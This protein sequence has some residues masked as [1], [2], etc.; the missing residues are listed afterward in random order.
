MSMGIARLALQKY[1]V[2]HSR[3]EFASKLQFNNDPLL[4][5]VNH[6]IKCNISFSSF[7]APYINKLPTQCTPGVVISD[8]FG[9]AKCFEYWV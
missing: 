2:C 7:Y 9:I 1:Y 4:Y 6:M 3:N 8:G 5:V